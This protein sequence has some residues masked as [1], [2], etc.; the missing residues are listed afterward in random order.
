ME[1]KG[2]GLAMGQSRSAARFGWSLVAVAVLAAWA[3]GCGRQGAGN[4]PVA[5]VNGQNVTLNDVWR[6]VPMSQKSAAL[7]FAVERVLWEGEAKKA[8]VEVT[9]ADVEKEIEL[10]FGSAEEMKQY[11]EHNGMSTD[12]LKARLRLGVIMTRICTRNVKLTEDDIKAYFEAH[13]KEGNWDQ[14]AQ[15]R[16]RV[17][18]TK[19]KEQ[20]NDALRK[21]KTGADFDAVATEYAL[22]GSPRGDIGWVMQPALQPRAAAE[23]IFDAKAKP[24]DLIG[25]IPFAAPVQNE[26]GSQVYCLFRIEELK[27]AKLA[28]LD[29]P[30]VRALVERQALIAS[31]KA[32][33]QEAVAARLRSE[34]KVQIL[35]PDFPQMQ[36]QPADAKTEGTAG[37]GASPAESSAATGRGKGTDTGASPDRGSGQS[38][39]P[40]SPSDAPGPSGQAKTH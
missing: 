17:V 22:E 21:L 14:P 38:S 23:A 40:V 10:Q 24:G 29:D 19:T 34:A 7:G 8:G 39:R 3:A 32:E 6:A 4:K 35:S 25:P 1:R 12:D 13:K 28:S 11:A 2:V 15:A 31:P 33:K 16:L 30:K 9:D 20:A 36:Q 5:V 27:P 37:S 18:Y 26:I